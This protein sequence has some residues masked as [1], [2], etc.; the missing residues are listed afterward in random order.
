MPI[1]QVSNLLFSNN[2]A[3]VD[4][5]KCVMSNA[6]GVGGAPLALLFLS[7]CRTAWLMQSK[8]K[9]PNLALLLKSFE[10]I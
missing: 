4:T 7:T 9:V 6:G 8:A 5:L 1:A 3:W 10:N 2:Q